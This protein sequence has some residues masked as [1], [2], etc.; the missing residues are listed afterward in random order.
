[1]SQALASIL[2]C[3]TLFQVKHFV[4]DFILQSRYQYMNKG[5]YGHPGGLL[6]ASIHA[7]GSA[8]PV[9]LL[10]DDW[11]LA[12]Y[13]I[14]GEWMVH[15]HVDWL[16][17]QIVKRRGLSFD[18][19]LFWAVFGTDQLLHQMTYVVMIAVLVRMAGL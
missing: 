8:G 13:L 6:H 18:G 1:M 7:A 4:C 2:W 3:L 14:A 12:A 9:L 10:T 11:E 16:K 19:A 15:Y 17:E 5:K